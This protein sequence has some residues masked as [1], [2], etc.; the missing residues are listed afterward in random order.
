MKPLMFALTAA[1]AALALSA[2]AQSGAP[3]GGGWTLEKRQD[4]LSQ[5]LA[6]AR[7]DGSVSPEDYARNLNNLSAI[8]DMAARMRAA[9]GDR[10]LTGGQTT[11]LEA[12]L[13]EIAD[14]IHFPQDA[15]YERPW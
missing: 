14:Q 3:D 5:H 9:D 15:K 6:M 10:P 1:V 13:D 12:N 2:H 8:N 4:W 11:A 7:D